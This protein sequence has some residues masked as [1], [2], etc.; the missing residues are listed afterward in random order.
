LYEV[1]SSSLWALVWGDRGYV[2]KCR[3]RSA[4]IAKIHTFSQRLG[5]ISDLK[6][7][8]LTFENGFTFMFT[9]T[10]FETKYFREVLWNVVLCS[11]VY[12]SEERTASIHRV[13]R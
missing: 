13:E 7:E 4:V 3:W 2:L 8:A 12:A 9:I 6:D 11:L 1:F 5:Q 10:G